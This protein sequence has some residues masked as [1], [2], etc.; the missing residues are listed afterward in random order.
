MGG[1]LYVAMGAWEKRPEENVIN[2]EMRIGVTFIS[3]S[4]LFLFLS[5]FFLLIFSPMI[6]HYLFCSEKKL[7]PKG[8]PGNGSQKWNGNIWE[9]KQ[10][11]NELGSL[12][13]WFL[14]SVGSLCTFSTH[15]AFSLSTVLLP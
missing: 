8:V 1:K 4:E 12:P 7:F 10:F 2:S 9:L 11:R 14:F 13:A 15:R 5:F 6:T 3:L